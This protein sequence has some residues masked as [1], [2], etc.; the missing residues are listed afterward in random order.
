MTDEYLL[1]I[2][3]DNMVLDGRKICVNLPRFK[4]LHK[5]E[6][7]QGKRLVEKGK[8]ADVSKVCE[9]ILKKQ[10]YGRNSQKTY[11]DALNNGTINEGL[12]SVGSKSRE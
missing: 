5:E 3:L 6:I 4:R 9:T 1:S 11:A 7:T 8:K 2:K 12:K 10:P